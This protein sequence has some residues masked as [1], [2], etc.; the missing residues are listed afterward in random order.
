MTNIG[1]T[2]LGNFSFH[3]PTQKKICSIIFIFREKKICQNYFVLKKNIYQNYFF[4]RKKKI[5][6]N[7]F[8][9]RR[10]C[11]C[12]DEIL[13]PEEEGKVGRGLHGEGKERTLP[14]QV[15]RMIDFSYSFYLI[16]LIYIYLGILNI[17]TV[18]LPKYTRFFVYKYTL[19]Y[20][21]GKNNRF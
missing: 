21:V 7:Y 16:I 8:C 11:F 18:I 4:I 14:N 19:L 6:C 17:I 15:G 1:V 10:L 5:F 12:H 9:I 2:S 13:Q 3:I 20:Q